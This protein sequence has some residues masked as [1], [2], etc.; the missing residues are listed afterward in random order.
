MALALI[1]VLNS[2]QKE[3]ESYLKVVP[4]DAFMTMSFN[5]ASLSQKGD[6]ANDLMLKG[7][8]SMLLLQLK[9]EAQSLAQE[10]L[11]NPAKSGIDFTKPAVVSV[12]GDNIVEGKAEVAIVFAVDDK[13]AVKSTFETFGG[14]YLEFNNVGDVTTVSIPTEGMSAAYDGTSLLLLVSQN[15]VALDFM[16]LPESRQAVACDPNFQPSVAGSADIACY[17]SYE[18]LFSVLPKDQ[19]AQ[20][21]VSDEMM[22][23]YKEVSFCSTTNFENGKIVTDYKIYNG[24]KLKELFKKF[25]REAT[26]KHF[27]YVPEKAMAVLS[28]GVQNIA[29]LIKLYPANV[30]EVFDN[31]FQQYGSKTSDLNYIEGDITLAFSGISN[32]YFPQFLVAID[33]NTDSIKAK[34]DNY[35]Q[36]TDALF[37]GGLLEKVSEN[38][39]VFNIPET[40]HFRIYGGDCDNTFYLMDES[41]FNQLVKENKVEKLSNSFN[42][43]PL[44]A[45]IKKGGVAI[46]FKPIVP[47]VETLMVG[48]PYQ[49]IATNVLS[50]FDNIVISVDMENYSSSMVLQMTDKEKNSLRQ[51]IELGEGLAAGM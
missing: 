38:F 17:M 37:A 27:D 1:A 42:A 48:N 35:K 44:A 24:E 5:C 32:N 49:T 25:N 13:E 40:D 28:F 10:L 30:Q 15:H 26:G 39:C 33:G 12:F 45:P 20:S 29:E 36:Q 2:C 47:M 21:G 8:E 43:N 4:E 50:K 6:L 22:Q 7:A 14:E 41:M 19:L 51:L 23:L 11:A 16:N 3:S 9:P 18:K 46:D 34:F 31:F